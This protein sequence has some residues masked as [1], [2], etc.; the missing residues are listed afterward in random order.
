MIRKRRNKKKSNNKEKGKEVKRKDTAKIRQVLEDDDSTDDK[1]DIPD[2]CRRGQDSSNEDEEK[3]TKNKEQKVNQKKEEEVRVKKKES[4]N[5][6][7]HH[8]RQ[9]DGRLE[10]GGQV[11]QQGKT[12]EINISRRD[13]ALL[14]K[15]HNIK[16]SKKTLAHLKKC[17]PHQD[18]EVFDIEM[19][20]E[21]PKDNLQ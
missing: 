17:I 8:P 3:V 21:I 6:K 1:D 12:M 11:E 13:S 18:M 19:G 20:K 4:D 7:P 10:Q 15:L 2:L 14:G 9:S 16:D 5:K